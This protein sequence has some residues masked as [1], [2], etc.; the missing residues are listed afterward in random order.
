MSK[1]YYVVQ[2]MNKT[3]TVSVLG[4]EKEIELSWIEGQIGAMPIF[5]DLDKAL[6]YANKYGYYVLELKV[7]A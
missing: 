5:D 7:M 3:A 2:G 1:K 4:M 6:S